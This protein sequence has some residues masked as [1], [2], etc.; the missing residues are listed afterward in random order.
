MSELDGS[1][2]MDDTDHTNDPQTNG[3]SEFQKDIDL[4]E[5]LIQYLDTV[6]EA[7]KSAHEKIML[8]LDKTEEVRKKLHK[9]GKLCWIDEL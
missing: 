3:R 4:R 1:N 9:Q 2:T 6:Y 5:H 8:A 7:N